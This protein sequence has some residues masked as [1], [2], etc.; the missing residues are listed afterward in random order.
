LESAEARTAA[1]GDQERPRNPKL[2][3]PSLVS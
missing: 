1:A 3:R 2:V